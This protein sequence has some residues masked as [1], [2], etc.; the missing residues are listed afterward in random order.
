M[1]CIYKTIYPARSIYD[2]LNKTYKLDTT[3][4]NSVEKESRVRE[5]RAY[6]KT[7][8]ETILNDKNT[9]RVFKRL[10]YVSDMFTQTPLA[11]TQF[12]DIEQLNLPIPDSRP[13]PKFDSSTFR[14]VYRSYKHAAKDLADKKAPT[15][16]NVKAVQGGAIVL[17][18]VALTALVAKKY[19][20]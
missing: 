13:T 16:L 7:S 5:I 2:Q 11:E 20:Q 9:S 4:N 8:E 17:G 19:M 18:L 1:S 14:R 6:L 3:Q 12:K 15:N 10:V